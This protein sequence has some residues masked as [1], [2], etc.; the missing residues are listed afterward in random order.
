MAMNANVKLDE[1]V[2]RKLQA[3][4]HQNGRS[5]AEVVNSLL[6][7]SFATRPIAEATKVAK[8]QTF[9]VEA[10]AMGVR[11]GL[12]YSRIGQLLEQLEGPD[13]R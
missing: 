8:R 6:R 13:Y 4:M 11:E 2:L 12:D 10:R 1:D 5:L 9:V 3:V 7:G